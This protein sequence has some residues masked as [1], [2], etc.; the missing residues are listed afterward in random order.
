MDIE[1]WQRAKE[2][3]EQAADL[4]PA[5]R[6]TFLAEKCRDN[7]PLRRAVDRLLAADREDEPL[8][9]AAESGDVLKV[10]TDRRDRPWAGR[11]LGAY[12][13]LEKIGSGGM[14]TVF[15]ARRDDAE[16]HKH[17]AIKVLPLWMSSGDNL[18]R[19]RRE[20]QI[21]ALL[22]HPNIAR[23]LDG[24]T[25]E[26]GLPY[27]VMEYV[28]GA[29]I[30][31]FCDHGRL[32]V[33]TRVE[34]MRKVCDAV[35]Y[36][37]RRLIVHRDLKA[38]NILVTDDGEPKLLDFGIAK[39]IGDGS[40]AEPG[41]E[42]H[43]RFMTPGYAGPEQLAGRPITTAADVYSLG[44]LLYKLLV[45]RLPFDVRGLS[46][47]EIADTVARSPPLPP[48]RA[49]VASMGH[50]EAAEVASA[51][52]TRPA[53]LAR[54]LAGDLDNICLK[55]LRSDPELRYRSAAELGQ[56]LRRYR[57]G[58]PV[59]ARP[60]R[61]SY[62]LGKFVRRHAVASTIALTSFGLITAFGVVTYLQSLRIAAERDVARQEKQKAE[63]VSRLL[64]ESFNTADPK[65]S[66]GR[67]I[68]AKEILDNGARHVSFELAN[69]P[70]LEATMLHTIGKVHA[71]LGHFEEAR[72]LLER[73]LASRLE[74]Y[75]ETHPETAESLHEWG[76]LLLSE[77]KAD[78]AERE[79]ERALDARRR[80]DP[81]RR[82]V[83]L[84]RLAEAKRAQGERAEAIA[85]HE[86]ALDMQRASLG[87]E[88]PEVVDGL[89]R[90]AH[91]VRLHGDYQRAAALYDRS[92]AIQQRLYDGDH[93]V[94]AEILLR[95]S[96]LASRMDRLE[97][98]ES[99]GREA[100]DMSRRIYGD[101]HPTVVQCLD[102]VA[103]IERKRGDFEAA[104]GLFR[105]ALSLQRSL[106]GP[107]HPRLAGLLYN[108][109]LLMHRD[110]GDLP[111]AES[112]YREAI[113]T[114]QRSVGER[115]VSYG[116]FRLGLGAVWID[117]GRARDAE[118]ILRDTLRLFAGLSRAG[119]EGR[120]AAMA[121]G[122]LAGALLDLG[123]FAEAEELLL[124]A[125]P[126]LVE[127]FGAEHPAAR[128][129]LDRLRR[130]YRRT[131]RPE[132]AESLGR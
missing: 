19:F 117:Q 129:A 75:G 69:Q 87:D 102:A 1:L 98:A 61:W 47:A 70:E 82:A 27:L 46:A 114:W 23:L 67:Q 58:L 31:S 33:T 80:L 24:G 54:R 81:D 115:H 60:A 68:T 65:N 113:E 100:L 118:P 50:G 20:R 109:A 127:H 86:Q 42:T 28:E 11:Q 43:G 51:R 53:L 108:L 45:G 83:T 93:P 34:L 38:G 5:A 89:T 106:L 71:R 128:R 64:V 35:D 125:R 96:R 77:G 6:D 72:P 18:E 99:L 63:Q 123:R 52:G 126:V 92:L 90:L 56:D 97:R 110:L 124:V 29:P 131:G 37:H 13:V 101:Q 26:E 40:G 7:P 49:L 112:L 119:A 59:V 22:E 105:E 85:L 8:L 111:A 95:M 121:K 84:H 88:H 107:D 120:N 9:P 91:S 55:A 3:F 44:V 25:T 103:N 94:T 36:A 130:L 30:T 78:E 116:F 79:F 32:D 15:L 2:I 39:L 12:R 21:L 41:A 17:V 132:R 76:V 48:S 66:R 62:R 74:L 14:G 10:L 104:E 16:F 73:S 4:T 122:E 57:H